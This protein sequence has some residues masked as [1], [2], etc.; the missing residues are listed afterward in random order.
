MEVALII[1]ASTSVGI[2]VSTIKNP[3]TLAIMWIIIAVNFIFYMMREK[4]LV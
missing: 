2:T 1:I 3:D 4:P